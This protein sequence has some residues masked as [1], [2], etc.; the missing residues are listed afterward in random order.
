M[1][2]YMVFLPEFLNSS[3]MSSPDLFVVILI[4]LLI[5]L[6]PAPGL[7]KMF[8]KAG[9]PSWKAWVPFLNTWEIVKLAQIRKHWWFWQFIPVAGWF[10][11]IWLLIECVK[12]FGKF[13]LYEHAAAAFVPFIYFPYLGYS[14]DERYLGP[15]VVKKHKKSPTRE[16]I[17]AAIFAIV[18]ATLIRV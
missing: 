17:D 16:W 5:V 9:V 14:K 18:A 8:Q 1:W 7:H 13:R 2:I 12:L 3:L 6:L 11:S 10:I 15:E 4:S